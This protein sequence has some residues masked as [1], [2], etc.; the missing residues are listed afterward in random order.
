MTHEP[1]FLVDRMLGPLTRYLRLLGYDT[2]SADSLPPGNPKEDT[3]LLQWAE[4]EE[5]ILLTRDRELAGRAGGRGFYIGEKEILDQLAF[6]KERGLIDL[7]VRLIRCS[8]CNSLLEDAPEEEIRGADYAPT[9]ERGP[10]F[11]WCPSCRRLYWMG[12]HTD[13]IIGRIDTLNQR[14]E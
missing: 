14:S 13:D 11:R 1:R 4:R 5:R 10:T 6:L 2:G 9:G 7:S 12:S 3:N 8:I